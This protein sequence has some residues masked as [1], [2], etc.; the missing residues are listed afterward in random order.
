MLAT[1]ASKLKRL[2]RAGGVVEVPLKTEALARLFRALTM[3][4]ESTAALQTEGWFAQGL[5]DAD[6]RL[7]ADALKRG[8]QSV[9]AAAA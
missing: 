5:L 7:S 8:A 2:H 9:L 6:S 3:W 1:A 4:D